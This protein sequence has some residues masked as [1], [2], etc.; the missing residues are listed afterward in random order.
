MVNQA[1]KHP[2]IYATFT[3]HIRPSVMFF[4]GQSTAELQ[5]DTEDSVVIPVLCAVGVVV[6]A[7]VCGMALVL[8]YKQKRK[9]QLAGTLPLFHSL[10]LS[11][12]LSL[13]LSLAV[14]LS[15]HLQSIYVPNVHS[16]TIQ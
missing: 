3:A 5:E 15:P 12:S 4:T 8:Y 13:S 14:S 9:K 6:V 2:Y 1:R 10:F 7:T 11:L 16:P